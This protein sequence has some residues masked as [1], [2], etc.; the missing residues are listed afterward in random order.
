MM[1]FILLMMSACTNNETLDTGYLDVSQ[2]DISTI[3]KPVD[4]TTAKKALPYDIKSPSY[5]PFEHEQTK[6]VISGWEN[7]KENIVSFIQYPST[8]EDAKWQEGSIS[9]P[10]IPHIS[11][12]IANFDRYYS[13]YSNTGDYI[14]VDIND[15][16][17]GLF[18]M[19]KA[20]KGAELHWFNGEMEYNLQLIYFSDDRDKLKTELLKI[21]NSI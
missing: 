13:R 17:T 6:V 8:E 11:Y 19:N 7:S 5:F 21:A 18:K 4:K 20:I 16:I 3:Y 2:E 9:Q 14:D 10:A 12:T 1:I 15:D